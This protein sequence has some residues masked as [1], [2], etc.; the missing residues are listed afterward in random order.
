[1]VCVKRRL[2]RG[3]ASVTRAT[4][5]N[6]QRSS[7]FKYVLCHVFSMISVFESTSLKVWKLF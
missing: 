1:M 6:A 7:V 4:R 3:V 5:L 2:A